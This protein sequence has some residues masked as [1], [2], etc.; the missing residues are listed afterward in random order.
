[1]KALSLIQPWAS[2]LAGGQKR[3]ETRSWKTEYRGPVLICASKRIP[4]ACKK[5]GAEPFF[6]SSLVGLGITGPE[7]LPL[8]MALGVVDLVEVYPVADIPAELRTP[9]ELAFGDYSPGRFG[10]HCVNARMFMQPFK[11]RGALGL[12][13]IDDALIPETLV[14]V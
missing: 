8:G 13:D 1:M 14:V 9:R 7:R 10:W 4:D 6:A 11:V 5:L 3:I 2:L 12:F